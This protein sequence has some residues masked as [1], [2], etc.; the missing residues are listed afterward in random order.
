VAALFI[1]VGF[2]ESR[3]GTRI[4]DDFGGLWKSLPLFGT[5]LLT[6]IM[7]SIGLPGLSG[8]PGELTML[9]GVFQES[10]AAAAFA[11]LGI[12][13]GAWY[14]LNLFRQAFGGPMDA[15]GTRF[16]NRTMPDLRRR[17]A[18]IL[19]PLVVLMFLIGILPNLILLPTEAAVEGLLNRA[20]ER[21]VGLLDDSGTGAW[22]TN[23]QD[24][25]AQDERARAERQLSAYNGSTTSLRDTS[26]RDTLANVPRGRVLKPPTSNPQSWLDGL[27]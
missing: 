4:I 3:R 24:E 2:L 8:F 13:L 15:S 6:V 19:L 7:A 17:E 16:E 27:R 10:W 12:V 23:P 1:F 18:V 22:P 11:A 26:S 5:L 14:M 21:R 20:D 25:G 9:L